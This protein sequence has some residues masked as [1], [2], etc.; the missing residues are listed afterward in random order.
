M[1]RNKNLLLVALLALTLSACH[2]DEPAPRITALRITAFDTTVYRGDTLRL[3]LTATP[4]EADLSEIVWTSS[5]TLVA[6]VA[7]GGLVRCVSPGR[8]VITAAMKGSSIAATHTVTVTPRATQSIAFGESELNLLVGQQ[9]ST[10]IRFTPESADDRRLTYTSSDSSVATV[11]SEGI[12]T[13]RSRGS[14]LITAYTAAGDK[15]AT[16][17]VTVQHF[18]DRICVLF[19][20][21]WIYAG[22]NRVTTDA[23]MTLRNNSD[24][25]IY[26][27]RF[28]IESDGREI[29]REEIGRTLSS[30]DRLACQVRIT[31]AHDP[32]FKYHFTVGGEQYEAHYHPHMIGA[33]ALPDDGRRPLPI[34]ITKRPQR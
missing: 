23:R 18:T 1:N 16:C 34:V 9:Q 15:T 10:A 13:A 2:K 25:D 14:A 17:R 20:G 6:I 11:S 7:P 3:T 12:V 26:V 19:S 22:N 8:A 32:Q 30:G 27:E 5:D 21:T 29:H 33:K 31:D 28:L 24:R 4:P